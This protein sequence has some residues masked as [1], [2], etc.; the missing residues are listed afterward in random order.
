MHVRIRPTSFSVI[1]WFPS[2]TQSLGLSIGQS[3]S[4]PSNRRSLPSRTQS[5]KH[6]AKIGRWCASIMMRSRVS[7]SCARAA[8]AY[9]DHISANFSTASLPPPVGE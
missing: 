9:L 8:G 5:I 2:L 6:Y 3:F 1:G 4:I 7:Q